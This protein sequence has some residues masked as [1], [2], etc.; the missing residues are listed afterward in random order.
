M[1]PAFRP[2]SAV[3]LAALAL[4][5]GQAHADEPIRIYAAG[6]LGAVMKDLVAVSGLPE[7]AMAL[8]VFGPAG[9]LRQRLQSGETADLFA[10]A[11]LAQPRTLAGDGAMP[12][13]PFARHCM[14]VLA[15]ERS[16]LSADTLLEV[17]PPL[18]AGITTY[19]PLRHWRVGPEDRDHRPL[20]VLS[21]WASSSPRRS[22]RAW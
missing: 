1:A 18:C 21:T 15:R 11:D 17:G 3:L 5:G 4:T 8:P 14:C 10:S 6:N 22:A 9:A 7:G 20:A 12:V 2:P 19:S 13:V 16:G